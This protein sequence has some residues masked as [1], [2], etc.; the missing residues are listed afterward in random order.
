MAMLVNDILCHGTSL[1][2]LF[3]HQLF[4]MHIAHTS[5]SAHSIFVFS[6]QFDDINK[7]DEATD[8]DEVREYMKMN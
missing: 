1:A 8:I 5:S 4:H 6:S 3:T 2:V 7:H